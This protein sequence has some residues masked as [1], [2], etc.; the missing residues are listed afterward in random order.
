MLLL[1]QSPDAMKNELGSIPLTVRISFLL[2]GWV[3]GCTIAGISEV[4]GLQDC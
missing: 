2:L 1:Q 4:A 3:T